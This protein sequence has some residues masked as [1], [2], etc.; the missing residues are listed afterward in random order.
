MNEQDY[1]GYA[2]QQSNLTEATMRFN[3]GMDELDLIG[4][5]RLSIPIITLD[6]EMWI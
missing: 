1:N 4:Y 3:D 2:F 5:C 6:D